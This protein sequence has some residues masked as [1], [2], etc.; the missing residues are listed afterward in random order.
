MLQQNFT[1]KVLMQKLLVSDGLA[2][3]LLT[4]QSAVTQSVLCA[5]SQHSHTAA[6]SCLL[7][8][9]TAAAGSSTAA[10]SCYS[11]YTSSWLCYSSSRL[12]YSLI[13]VNYSSRDNRGWQL[14]GVPHEELLQRVSKY[15]YFMYICL[16]PLTPIPWSFFN[17]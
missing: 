15:I 17:I 8:T 9:A 12:L 1:L 10:A 11:C 16:K 14:L 4:S 3:S 2:C 6:A 13:N 5:A 7:T